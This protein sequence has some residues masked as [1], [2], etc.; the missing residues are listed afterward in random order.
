M[1]AIDNSENEVSRQFEAVRVNPLAILL[2]GV[3]LLGLILAQPTVLAN[4]NA[5]PAHVASPDVYKVLAE[6]D[7]F[8][9]IEATWQPG[10]ED[11]YHS[12]PADRV[13]LYQTDCS[14]RL[15]S[16]DGSTRIGKP[17]A[18]TAKAR[19]GKPV[20]SHKAKNL[21]DQVCIIRIVELK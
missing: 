18:G 2:V 6:N 21:G 10:Q 19:T 14:L 15:T 8:R 4:D 3:G 11:N 13:S 1:T 9:V 5:P 16:S 17:K 20:K 7:Q 12:H